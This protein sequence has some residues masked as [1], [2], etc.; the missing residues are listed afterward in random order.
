MSK[1]ITELK[2]IPFYKLTN[3]EKKRLI[4][5]TSDEVKSM[6]ATTHDECVNRAVSSMVLDVMRKCR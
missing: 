3:E 2:A 5:D 4:A 1:S 6:P